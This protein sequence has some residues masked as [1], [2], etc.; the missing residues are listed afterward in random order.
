MAMTA[1]YPGR[2]V[3]TGQEFGT[4]TQIEMV[5]STRSSLEVKSLFDQFATSD[6][7]SF[8]R[9]HVPIRLAQYAKDDLISRS[10]ARRVLT[11]FHRFQEV[12]LDFSGVDFIGQ[13]FADEI[14]RVFRLAHPGVSLSRINAAPDVERMIRR[15]SI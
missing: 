10:Q 5:V 6:D 2:C 12:L 4:G 9:T 8:S 3:E 14:V 13:A 1:R 7:L 15:A 11:R